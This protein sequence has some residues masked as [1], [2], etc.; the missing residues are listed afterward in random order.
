MNHILANRSAGAD[1]RFP[2]PRL[3][4]KTCA[5]CGAK[6]DVHQA[7][8]GGIC[9]E[10]ACRRKLVME[11][12]SQRRQ[13]EEADVRRAAAEFRARV[14]PSLGAAD[15]R[16]LTLAVVPDFRRRV[17]KLP[18]ARRMEFRAHLVRI[19]R[20]AF[21]E[22]LNETHASALA[23]E[24]AL[25]LQPAR[26]FREASACCATCRGH[27]CRTGGTH[28]YLNVTV[29]RSYLA[30]HPGLRWRE[31]VRVFL[32]KLP[33]AAFDYSCV[34]HGRRGCALPRE[35]R[36]STCNLYHCEGLRELRDAPAAAGPRSVL[37][38]AA[39]S[40]RI[41]R[42]ALIHADGSVVQV[43]KVRSTPP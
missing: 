35:M 3:S 39:S 27:C 25:T 17:V 21:E 38:V 41:G 2:A 8:R 28:A 13:E 10:P 26:E 12:A 24:L 34:Y 23:E 19:V 9:A 7:V 11:S 37:V 22:M 5:F 20:Q 18:R 4:E 30:R 33:A 32:K 31:V 36:S 16:S 14:A 6:L 40:E 1:G 29:I 15:P 42:S 43:R